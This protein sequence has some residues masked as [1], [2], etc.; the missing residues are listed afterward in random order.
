MQNSPSRQSS[1]IQDIKA[2]KIAPIYLIAGEE[3]FLV[4]ETV[5]QLLDLLL[6][7]GS[8]DFNLDI[9]DGSQ[10]SVREILSA[11]EVYPVIADWRVVLVNDPDFLQ[12]TST[13]NSISPTPEP[14]EDAEDS[15]SSF[16]G[17]QTKYKWNYTSE[18]AVTIPTYFA[19]NVGNGESFLLYLEN[20]W[21]E[22][23]LNQDQINNA[24]LTNNMSSK[25]EEHNEQYVSF[26]YASRH[27]WT[28]TLSYNRDNYK[29]TYPYL[30][31]EKLRDMGYSNVNVI[32]AGVGNA[33]TWYSLINLEFRVL[34]LDVDYLIT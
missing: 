31:G 4:T 16:M 9:F 26:S 29:K 30:M 34:D 27:S 17:S 28:V 2:G 12:P 8:R 5:K 24:G 6:D 10:I 13:N 7:S 15:I 25:L 19:W 23:H 3:A 20:Q 11:V 32:N 22:K 21:R 33:D 18:K 1:L 14:I